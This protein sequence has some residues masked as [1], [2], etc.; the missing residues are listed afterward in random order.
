[1]P[2]NASGT[3][4]LAKP[5]FVAGTTIVSADMNSDLSDIATGLTESLATTGV[6]VMTG[7]LKLAAGTLGAPSLTLASDLTTGFYNN[8]AGALTYVAAGV[9]TVILSGTGISTTSLT[10]SG[11]ITVTSTFTANGS[12]VIVGTAVPLAIRNSTNDA[13]EHTIF[14]AGLGSGAGNAYGFTAIGTGANDIAEVRH[15]IGATEIFRFTATVVT[16][17]ASVNLAINAAKAINVGASL[18]LNGAGYVDI[19]EIAA[20][21]DPAANVARV[22]AKDFGGTTELYYRDSAGVENVLSPPGSVIGRGYGEYTGTTTF[23]GSIPN[24]DTIPQNTEGDQIV[25]ATITLQKSTNRVRA[26]FSGWC[27]FIDSVVPSLTVALF[28]S[29]SANAIN[30]QNQSSDNDAPAVNR[31]ISILEI[32]H[33]PGSVGP[34]TYQ[35]RSGGAG[36]QYSWNT[37]PVG[38]R[39]YG[40]ASRATLILEEIQV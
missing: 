21:A 8:A 7:P 23:S 27:S 11:T 9:A 22:Y 12:A 40:G 37:S 13:A 20:P 18:S 29:V 36:S 32:E 2:R 33:A 35:V 15:Y 38:S 25:T 31:L 3:F 5:A 17:S 26:R 16:L 19:T 1:M 39:L 10:A 30:A 24:D 6:S 4:S 28:S 34:L 14:I